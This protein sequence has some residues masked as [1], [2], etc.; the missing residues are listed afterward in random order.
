MC[1]FLAVAAL[2]YFSKRCVFSFGVPLLCV[3]C[4][5]CL[6]EIHQHF[7]GGRTLLWQD[8]VIDTIGGLL[9]ILFFQWLHA[10]K[11]MVRLNAGFR[12]NEFTQT[13]ISVSSVDR[14]H[15]P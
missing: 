10:L 7:T 6:D 8:F 14:V 1:G 12:L 13:K 2:R 3:F 9:G 5:A 4:Y 11:R 15:S